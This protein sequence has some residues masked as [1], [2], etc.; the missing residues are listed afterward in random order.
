MIEAETTI[1]QKGQVTI[2]QAIRHKLGLQPRDRVRFQMEG[3][4]VTLQPARSS[5]RQFYQS[6]E[7]LTPPRS[8]EEMTEIAAEEHAQEAAGEGRQP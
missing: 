1:T 5:I 6:V 2:P 3:D 7:A 8:V 4:V